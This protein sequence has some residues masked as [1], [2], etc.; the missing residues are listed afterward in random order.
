MHALACDIT[1]NACTY[2]MGSK[3]SS[4][5]Q[6]Y[7]YSC[8]FAQAWLI[9]VQQMHAINN[10]LLEKANILVVSIFEFD[11]KKKKKNPSY[12]NFETFSSIF[13]QTIRQTVILTK[14]L[15]KK[16]IL[17]TIKY[18][19][20]MRFCREILNCVFFSLPQGPVL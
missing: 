14:Y 17:W 1:G 13:A 10:M 4:L 11:K 15:F 18:H 19:L 9:F 8:Y 20:H 16:I 5:S 6:I 3:V 7:L 12:L 2:C